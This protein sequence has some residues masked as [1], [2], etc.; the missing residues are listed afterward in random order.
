[1]LSLE[2]WRKADHIETERIPIDLDAVSF[3][4]IRRESERTGLPVEDVATA[5]LRRSC[6]ERTELNFG[7]KE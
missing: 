3:E 6:A 1:M 5:L 2:G 4:W 7:P